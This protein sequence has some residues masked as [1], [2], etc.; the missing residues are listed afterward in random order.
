MYHCP[1]IEVTKIE[2]VRGK[3]KTPPR[4]GVAVVRS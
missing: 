3:K 2:G 4:A 1:I